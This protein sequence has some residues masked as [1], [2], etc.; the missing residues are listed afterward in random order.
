MVFW[1]GGG[2]GSNKQGWRIKQ[3]AHSQ[4]LLS[5]V[6]EFGLCSEVGGKP[7]DEFGAGK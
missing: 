2:D 7:S 4:G 3:R 1:G 6:R 5:P